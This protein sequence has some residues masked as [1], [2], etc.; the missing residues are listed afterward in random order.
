VLV[1]AHRLETDMGI[2]SKV[3]LGLLAGL[4]VAVLA[5]QVAAQNQQRYAVVEKCI[6]QA[7]KEWP[8]A[9]QQDTHRQ[10]TMSYEACMANAGLA[11]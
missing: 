2:T 5:S 7:Q 3:L 9:G 1:G 10:R 11:P 8:D 6:A 4:F